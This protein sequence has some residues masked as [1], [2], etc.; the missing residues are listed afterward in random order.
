MAAVPPN[1]IMMFNFYKM[2][3]KSR[4]KD[5]HPEV[6]TEQLMD[7]IFK[8]FQQSSSMEEYRQKLKEECSSPKQTPLSEVH[9]KMKK[10]EKAQNKT[11]KP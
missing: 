9:K 7:N 4:P 2:L 10:L 5:L 11:K 8:S 3:V 6:S 1:Q